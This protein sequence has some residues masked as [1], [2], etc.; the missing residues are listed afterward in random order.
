MFDLIN[1][2]GFT[3]IT[4]YFAYELA[5]LIES[6]RSRVVFPH[7]HPMNHVTHT[8]VPLV[9]LTARRQTPRLRPVSAVFPYPFVKKAS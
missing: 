3:L 2:I 9:D 4:G 7:S 1:L 6:V 5:L 8:S